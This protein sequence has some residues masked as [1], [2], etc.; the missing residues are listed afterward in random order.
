MDYVKIPG[1]GLSPSSL[2]RHHRLDDPA[3]RAAVRAV[4]APAPSAGRRP[5]GTL[6]RS[7]DSRDRRRHPGPLSRFFI[8]RAASLQSVRG[9]AFSD[10]QSR[11]L[12]LGASDSWPIF[13]VAKGEA[14]VGT[15]AFDKFGQPVGALVDDCEATPKDTLWRKLKKA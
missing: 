15:V 5:V 2:G 3:A 12:S 9:S 4:D 14:A 13:E 11:L 6:A 1:T 8:S 7:V 10:W